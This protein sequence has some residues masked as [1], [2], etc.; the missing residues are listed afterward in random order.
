LK[1]AFL[2]DVVGKIEIPELKRTIELALAGS[3]DVAANL[4]DLL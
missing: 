1:W 2:A 3:I 4:K